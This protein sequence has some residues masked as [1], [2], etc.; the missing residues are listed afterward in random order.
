MNV[1]EV[2]IGVMLMQ[3]AT[4][5][6][7]VIPALATLDTQA[8]GFL[9]TVSS[10]ISNHNRYCSLP[11]WHSLHKHSDIN[12]CL[13]NN[14]SCF[15]NCYD[16]DRS[17]NYHTYNPQFLT[18]SPAIYMQDPRLNLPSMCLLMIGNLP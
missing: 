9:A 11:A 18:P 16:L 1:L 8:M 13:N 14:G 17:Y 5:L 12:E 4:T 2:L 6:K 10:S 3:I 7:G 15:H